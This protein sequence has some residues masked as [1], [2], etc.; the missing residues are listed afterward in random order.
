MLS[1]SAVLW[2]SRNDKTDPNLRQDLQHIILELGQVTLL[3][4]KS[5]QNLSD[6]HLALR[7]RIDQQYQGLHE[8]LDALGQLIL[9]GKLGVGTS[10]GNNPDQ[11]L[12]L[13]ER[14]RNKSRTL[15]TLRV[16]ISH[17]VPCRK[18]CPC[19][20]HT[21]QKLKVTMPGVMKSLLG[22]MFVGYSGVPVLNKPC[23]FRGC[24][25]KQNLSATIEYWF[26]WW[27]VSMNLKLQLKY[28]QMAEPRL[29]LA[30]TRRVPDSSQ[31]INFAMKGDIEGLKF[32][33]SQ[34]LA[35]PRD[36]SDSRGYSLI[37]V[38]LFFILLERCAERLIVGALR[39]NA[40]VQNRPILA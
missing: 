36:A 21:K 12:P 37:R 5:D 10:P 26:P 22:K 9:S 38:R 25:D 28:T 19:A 20:C 18:W 7:A 23:D 24:K 32:L 27:L 6:H 11:D 14:E 2:R 15:D 3:T 30:T 1:S 31:S 17:R 8:R 40:S 13:H 16:Q 29:Q 34:G 33:F 35:S 4:S 39:R